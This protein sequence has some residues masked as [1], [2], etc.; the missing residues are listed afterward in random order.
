M[1][2]PWTGWALTLDDL[3]LTRMM[4]IAV[5]SDDLAV[6]V[7]LPTPAFPPRV[8][9]PVLGLLTALAVERHGQAAPCCAASA[10]GSARRRRSPRSDNGYGLIG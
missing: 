3:L 2:L 8:F 6:S 4:E 9:T 7:D 1:L 10:A 5:H